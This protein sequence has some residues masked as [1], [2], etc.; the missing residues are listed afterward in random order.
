MLQEVLKYRN[1]GAHELH[2]FML[3]QVEQLFVHTEQLFVDLLL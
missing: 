1:G 2:T 3:E